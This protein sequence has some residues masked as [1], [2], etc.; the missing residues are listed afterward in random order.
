MIKLSLCMIVKDE[1]EVLYRCL[2]SVTGLTPDTADE[3]AKTGMKFIGE[4]TESIT[5]TESPIDEIIIADT[6]STDNTKQIAKKFGA[7][8]YDF[9]WIN[10]FSAARNFAFSKA[11]GKYILWLDADDFIDDINRKRLLALKKRLSETGAVA[12]FC[13]YETGEENSPYKTAFYRTRIVKNDGAA[14][15]SGRVHEC[16]PQFAGALCDT[17]NGFTVRHMGSAKPRGTRNLDIYRAQVLTGEPFSPRDLFY[18]GRELFYHGFYAEADAIEEEF[19]RRT[20]GWYVNKIEARKI[21]AACREAKGDVSGAKNA[22]FSSFCTARRARAYCARWGGY[23]KAKTIF[24]LRISGIFRRIMPRIIPRKAIST[25]PPSAPLRLFW[26]WSAAPILRETNPFRAGGTKS[27][28]DFS[29]ITLPCGTI[30]NFFRRGTRATIQTRAKTPNGK[31]NKR[32][33]RRRN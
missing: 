4:T 33:K 28:C 1:E 11:T 5:V 31:K 15:W 2:S 19:T 24:L 12:A 20:D 29:P 27:V 10:D 21:Q 32:Q 22:L 18:Y 26:K 25:T 17:E 6:G 23:S 16:L 8:I 13:R 7:K 14:V 9:T 3:K 30:R